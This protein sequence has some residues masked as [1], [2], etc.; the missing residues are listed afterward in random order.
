M[1]VT[2][3]TL[4]LLDED[5]QWCKSPA[6]LAANHSVEP[7]SGAATVLESQPISCVSSAQ[8]WPSDERRMD[9]QLYDEVVR[10]RGRDLQW[11]AG[12]TVR[13]GVGLTVTW[14]VGL[15]VTWRAGLTV[16]ERGRDL[17]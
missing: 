8:L 14:R 12:L 1:L 5:H 9:I 3:E 6:T 16:R 4:Y 7:S 15:T 2:K 17:Q 13:E 11:R 10:E